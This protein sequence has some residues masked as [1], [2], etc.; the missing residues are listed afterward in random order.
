MR[1]LLL[2]PPYLAGFSRPQRSPAVPRSGALY[3]P[4]WLASCAAVLDRG[5]FEVQLVDA[6]A[7]GWDR[8]ETVA[9]AVRFMPD[10]VV[11][12]TSTPSIA[13]DMEVAG[14]LRA[15][16]PSTFM[17]LV[18]THVSALP[19]SALADCPAADAVAVGEYELTALELARSLASGMDG[20]EVLAAIRGLVFRD[21][22]DSRRAPD[23]LPVEDL[24]TL[25]WVSPVYLKHLDV[26]RYFNPNAPHPMVTLLGSRGCPHGCSF[27]L[28]PQT[29]TG[30]RF[31]VRSVGDLL[32][33][34]EFALRSFPG[35]RS[36]FFEDDT[37][38][39]DRERCRDLCQAILSRGLRFTWTA[40]GRADSDYGMLALMRRAGCRMVC[41][42]FESANAGALDAV[43]KGLSK[44]A[45]ERFMAAARHAGLLVHGCW[46]FGLPGDTRESVLRTIDL[47][48]RLGTDTAQFYPAIPYPGTVMYEEYKGRGWLVTEDYS[49][50]LTPAGQHACVVR[51]EALTPQAIDGLCRLARQRFYLRPRFLARRLWR[52]LTDPVELR[53]T[54]RAGRTFGR[55]LVTGA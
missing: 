11:M 4:A 45:A 17:L 34:V 26:S 38:A 19:E 40:N 51:T 12:D 18:G 16:L 47:A 52:S 20:P 13:S 43:G 39:A 8:A 44:G 27:C 15:A 1:A 35:L 31:R 54:L 30:R 22:P 50:W 25:P 6:S 9:A 32:D 41:V 33:E 21:G 49:R 3:Y 37:L 55:H 48:V 24:D 7:M 28:Y 2:N 29:M 36:I 10:L 5:G 42:G 53:R 14:L 46:I 23:R